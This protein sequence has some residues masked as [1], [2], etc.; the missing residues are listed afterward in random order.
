MDLAPTQE[1]RDAFEGALRNRLSPV[2]AL[3]S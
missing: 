3:A 1:L 2:T